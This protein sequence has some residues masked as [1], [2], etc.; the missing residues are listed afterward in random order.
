MDKPRQGPEPLELDVA[1]LTDEEIRQIQQ[2]F[3][4]DNGDFSICSGD[5]YE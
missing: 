3:E 4:E 1:E 5:G 2:E